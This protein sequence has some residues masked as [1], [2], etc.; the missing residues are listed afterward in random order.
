MRSP[1]EQ[2]M[3]NNHDIDEPRCSCIFC[4]YTSTMINIVCIIEIMFGGLIIP[5][6]IICFFL[7]IISSNLFMTN[8]LSVTVFFILLTKCVLMVVNGA[9]GIISVKEKSIKLMIIFLICIGLRC[10]FQIVLMSLKQYEAVIELF[11]WICL[12]F[13]FSRYYKYLKI[14]SSDISYQPIQ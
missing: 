3:R 12:G 7:G 4:V 14:V 9:I 10:I 13:E 6:F 1:P 5:I 2:A 11:I 8:G